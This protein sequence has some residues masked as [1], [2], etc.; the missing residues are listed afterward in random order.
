VF[1]AVPDH[2]T[3]Y[4]SLL[5]GEL[6][7]ITLDRGNLIRKASNDQE[8]SGFQTESSGAEIILINT[9]KPPL[10][11]IRVRRA[12][13]M[14]NNQAMHIKMVY[15]DTIPFIRHPFGEPFAC[16]DNGYLEY[17]PEQARQLITAFGRPVVIECLHSNTSRGR[18][19]GAVLQQLYKAI[20]VTL[21][22]VPLS[23]GP[24]VMKV[25]QKDYQMATWRIPPSRDH[26][27][28]LY[29]SFHSRSPTN[30]TGYNNPD[31]DRLLEMQRIET[32]AARRDDL[33]CRIVKQ[34]NS[35]APFL[36]R[37]GRRFHYVARKKIRDMMDTP[38]FMLD[39]ASAWMDE[40]IKFNTA[41][42]DIEQK[43]AVEE[44]DC[45]DPGNVEATKAMLL[46]SWKG[47][48][49]WGGTLQLTFNENDTVVG[50]RSGG[51]N[52]KGNFTI[53][54]KLARWKSNSGALVTMTVLPDRLE[55]TFERGGYGGTIS[56]LR[57]KV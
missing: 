15:G 56:M 43:A 8:L 22:P 12:L 34:L 26:G 24:Q 1:R 30:F 3:R 37:G 32:D 18:D 2:Q 55:G 27:P 44:F 20:G 35:D 51:Y 33:F 47:K 41:A 38:G 19:I 6:D 29:R 13:A 46:G 11:D 23:T 45:P 39:L 54:G 14:A 52:L 31:M 28:Q 10:D 17:D 36:Y 50:T 4:A 53:C 49:S 40:K 7:I 5:S 21:K 48:D 16:E 42:Y 57:E 25:L 9:D